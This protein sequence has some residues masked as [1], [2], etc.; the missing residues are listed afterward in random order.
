MIQ[1]SVG[2]VKTENDLH[3]PYRTAAV[4]AGYIYVSTNCACTVDFVGRKGCVCVCLFFHVWVAPVEPLLLLAAVASFM[5][6]LKS[7]MYSG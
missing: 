1:F 7:S 6:T 5:A 4:C 2:S 3:H